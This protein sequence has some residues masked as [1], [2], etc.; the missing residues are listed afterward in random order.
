[1]KKVVLPIVILGVAISAAT[2]LVRNPTRV[3][4]T[5]PDVQPISVRVI[6]V[7]TE[8]AHLLVNSQGKVQSAQRVNL[9]VPLA[10]A[11]TWISPMLESGGYVKANEILLRL[12]SSDYLTAVARSRAAVQQAQAEAQHGEAEYVRMSQLAAQGLASQAQLQDSL[13]SRSVTAA[14]LADAQVSLQQAELDLSRTELRAPFNAIIEGREVELGQY[15]NRA[16]TVAVLFGADEVEVR[17]PLAIRQLGFLD[18]P[19]GMRGEL[20]PERAPDVVLKGMYGGIEHKWQGKLVRVEA[21]ID[22]NS[23]AVQSIIRVKQPETNNTETWNDRERSM[24]LPIGLFVEAEI[25]GREVD[26]LMALP[27]SVIR[28]NNQVLV[29]DAENKM[30]LREVEIYRLEDERVLISSGLVPGERI[31]VSPIQAVYNGMSVQPVS[32][33]I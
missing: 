31:C 3:E 15:I 25:A 32:E 9:S 17:V 1:M 33:I 24:P 4:V 7:Q 11:V 29:V 12:D 5:S 6:Q 30:Y 21:S 16:Q 14:R 28:N 20:S 22:T 13:R 27:R 2:V 19:L 18:I 10:G 23:N 26:N 8:S